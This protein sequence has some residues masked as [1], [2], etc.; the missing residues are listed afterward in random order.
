M[1]AQ[2]VSRRY[3]LQISELVG[4]TI[5]LFVRQMSDIHNVTT[6][7]NFRLAALGKPTCTLVC[8]GGGKRQETGT[9]IPSV[10]QTVF[11]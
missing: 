9:P 3:H 10:R 11:T 6:K 2:V 5:L 8:T 7:S 4:K 1:D